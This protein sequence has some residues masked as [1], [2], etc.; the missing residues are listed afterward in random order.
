[1]PEF[2]KPV[3]RNIWVLLMLM[4]TALSPANAETLTPAQAYEKGKIL[5]FQDKFEEAEPYL[6]QAGES[7]YSAAY[8][9]IAN[10]GHLNRYLMS[11]KEYKF[12]K[13]AAENG[14][15]MAMIG[16]TMPRSISPQKKYWRNTIQ[17]ILS[18]HADKNNPLALQMQGYATPIEEYDEMSLLKTAAYAGYPKA[19]WKLARR[20]ES[21]ESWFFLPGSREKEVAKLYEAAARGGYHEAIWYKGVRAVKSGD[22]EGGMGI[23]QTLIDKGDASKVSSLGFMLSELPDIDDAWSYDDKMLGSTYLRATATA[24]SD[25]DDTFEVFDK[26][27]AKLLTDEEKV[28]VDKL[29][30]EYLSNHTVYKQDGLDEYEYTVDNLHT[31]LERWGGNAI[32]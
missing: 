15:L 25:F 13:L 21:G 27:A 19:Q 16:L 3:I 1:M 7:G 31:A 22:I 28:Q 5:H 2:A 32:E 29:A 10:A 24:M 20:Y 18:P 9:L 12:K 8:Y 11:D 30:E 26:E 23:L 14:H 17:N 6:L 4:L